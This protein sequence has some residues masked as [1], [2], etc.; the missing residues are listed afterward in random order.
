MGE[1]LTITDCNVLL[2]KINPDFFPRVFG[3]T[4]HEPLNKDLTQKAFQTLSEKV[5]KTSKNQTIEMIAEGFLNIAIEH[6]AEAVKKIS[7]Q[8][9]HNLDN[10]T[11]MCFGG[12]GAQHACLV[13]EAISVD[14]IFIHYYASLLSALGIGLAD[15]LCFYERFLEIPFSQEQEKK[16]LLTFEQLE[17]EAEATLKPQLSSDQIYATKKL[18]RLKY[19]G[20]D[21]SIEIAS[22]DLNF[23]KITKH[24][25]ESY[26]L[27]YGFIYKEKAIILESVALEAIGKQ[28]I[29]ASAPPSQRPQKTEI[30]KSC[31]YSKGEWQ[32]GFLLQT[33]DLAKDKFYPGPGLIVS[34]HTTIVVERDWIAQSLDGH[35]LL[36]YKPKYARKKIAKVEKDPILLEIF[37][38]RFMSIAEQMGEVLAQTAYSVNIKER[39]DFSCALFDAKGGLVA[40]AP[41]MPVHLGSMGESVS[42]VLRLNKLSAGDVYCLN[43]PYNGGTHLPDI[44]VVS[45]VFGP[46][47]DLLFVVASRGHHADIGG[48]TPGS[49]PPF[50]KTVL[51]EGVLIDNFKLVSNHHFEEEKFRNLLA[52]N[53]Y[54]ARNIDQNVADIKAQ[55]AAN[56]KGIQELESLVREYSQEVVLAYM[57]H[58]QNNAEEYIRRVISKLKDGSF[59]SFMDNGCKVTVNVKVNRQNRNVIIDFT[60]T[61]AQSESNF[62]APRSVT[63]AAVLYVMRSLVDAPIPLNEGCMRPIQLVIPEGSILSPDYPSAVVAGNV[64][65]SQIVTDTLYAALGLLANA[66]G[67][68]NNFT[69]GNQRYQYYETICGGSGA[70]PGFNGCDAIHTHMTNSRLTDVE[71]LENRYPIRVEE[72]S[73]RLN[74]G[75]SGLYKGGNGVIR[76]ILFLEPMTASIL[77]NHR[78]IAPKGIK[79]GDDAKLGKTLYLHNNQTQI[80]KSSESIE[81]LEG[82]RIQIETP[83]GGGFGPKNNL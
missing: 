28:K 31:F 65:T 78:I 75:G 12:A 41:H 74:S 64:E 70:G 6:M 18:F 52:N 61:S 76:R 83:G 51:E 47:G 48:I 11:L 39:L 44:T 71:V 68:M 38:N 62:N 50:S 1:N 14:K 35:V 82:D 23:K 46:S 36:E 8:E 80:L 73:I 34:P 32:E 63:R 54:P 77:S 45:P 7:I 3:S 60:G 29:T 49:M 59:T 33:E 53:P 66:Q 17:K 55:L 22:D 19:L 69:F 4:G 15:L 81:V 2:G 37:N 9:G 43:A 13:A 5:L 42:T 56:S 40:N 30:Q 67:T 21:S 79:G 72:F 25:E 58:V 16:I 10:A 27:K 24:Y 26:F 57:G 20:T